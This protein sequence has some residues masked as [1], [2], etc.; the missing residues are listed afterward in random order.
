MNRETCKAKIPTLHTRSLRVNSELYQLGLEYH[1]TLSW[2]LNAIDR[3]LLKY[4]FNTTDG[5]INNSG[6]DGKLHQEVGEGKW[7]T[8][9]WHVMDSGRY[10]IV[11]YLN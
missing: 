2:S 8:L 6:I 10:E 11:S 9:S 5:M 4:N 3:V 7:L 1:D